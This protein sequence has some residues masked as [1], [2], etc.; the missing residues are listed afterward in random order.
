VIDP[1][2][3]TV[4]LATLVLDEPDGLER[5]RRVQERYQDPDEHLHSQILLATLVYVLNELGPAPVRRI[6][7]KHRRLARADSR[8]GVGGPTRDGSAAV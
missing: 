3:W 2:A 8:A 4:E 6:R 7:A 5:I 1:H